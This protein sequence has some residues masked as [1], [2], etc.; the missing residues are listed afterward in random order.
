MTRR[1]EPRTLAEAAQVLALSV[2]AAARLAGVSSSQM[3]QAAATGEVESVRAFGR[4]LVKA[5]PF[6]AMF[7]AASD[8]GSA[9]AASS[10]S[11]APKPAHQST[12][13]GKC[14]T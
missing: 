7:G 8:V 2:P 10:S 11:L 4:V 14:P 1:R 5:V 3:Y 6:L 12:S 13:C 9:V